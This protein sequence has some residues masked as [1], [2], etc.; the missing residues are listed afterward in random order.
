MGRWQD[1]KTGWLAPRVLSCFHICVSRGWSSAQ[2]SLS[3]GKLVSKNLY[4]FVWS[5]YVPTL[6]ASTLSLRHNGTVSMVVFGV[7]ISQGFH[8]GLSGVLQGF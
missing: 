7:L 4:V 6:P 2:C 3:L 5:F 8:E 1:G